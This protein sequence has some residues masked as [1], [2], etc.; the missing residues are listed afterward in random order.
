MNEWFKKLIST[1]KEKWAKWS[2]LQKGI[3]IGVVVAVIVA[4]ILGFRFSA[5]PT[6]V[7]LFNAPITG[8]AQVQILTRLDKEILRLML[9]VQVIFAF[10]MRKQQHE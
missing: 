8:D 5:K 4:I 2:N 6:T 10:L 7:R 3:L 9:T 1:I